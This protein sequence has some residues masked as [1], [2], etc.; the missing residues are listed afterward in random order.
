MNLNQ[1]LTFHCNQKVL[2]LNSEILPQKN[3][4]YGSNLSQIT[5]CHLEDSGL[6]QKMNETPKH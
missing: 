2:L 4:S 5:F 1:S 3:K 6:G